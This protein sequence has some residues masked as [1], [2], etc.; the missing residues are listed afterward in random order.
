[1]LTGVRVLIVEDEPLIA[2]DLRSTF[3]DAGANVVCASSV[4]HAIRSIEADAVDLCVLDTQ[5][6]QGETSH[7]ISGLLR[8]RSV[9]F[10]VFS[11]YSAQHVGALAHL[12][13]PV[14]SDAVIRVAEAFLVARGSSN[15]Q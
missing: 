7:S 6:W 9:P 13:K 12:T 5:L 14:P 10:A 1:M 15:P 4:D 2:L 8:D 3:E 11:A